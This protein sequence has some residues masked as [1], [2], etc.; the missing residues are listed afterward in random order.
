MRSFFQQTGGLKGLGSNVGH[1]TKKAPAEA[2]AGKTNPCVDNQTIV[3]TFYSR[4]LASAR[5]VPEDM[6]QLLFCF[7]APVS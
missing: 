3:L 2:G 5:E 6:F 7:L 1:G 4:H